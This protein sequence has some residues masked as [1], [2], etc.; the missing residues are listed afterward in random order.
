[1]DID[2]KIIEL[3]EEDRERFQNHLIDVLHDRFW[4]R[5][6]GID[7]IDPNVQKAKGK[8]YEEVYLI[9]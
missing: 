2:K 7:Y 5:I 6:N 9:K 1:M 4:C 3:S 8:L